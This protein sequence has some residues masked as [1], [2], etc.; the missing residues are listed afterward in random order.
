MSELATSWAHSG[1]E[2]HFVLLAHSIDFYEVPVS[3]KIHRLG[4]RNSGVVAKVKSELTTLVKLRAKVREIQPDFVLSFMEKFNEFTLLSTFGLRIPVFVSDRANPLRTRSWQNKVLRKLTYRLARGVIA[5]TS[6]AKEEIYKRTRHPNIMVIPNPIREVKLTQ[7]GVRDNVIINVGRL[8]PEKGQ[9]YLIEAFS[10]LTDRRWR[11]QI[12]GDGPLRESLNNQVKELGL[13][14]RVEFTGAVTNVDD[15]LATASIFVFSSISEG[16]PNAL[17]EAMAAGLPCVSFDCTAGPRDIINQGS[18][19]Y[20]IPVGDVESLSGSITALQ[21]DPSK[22]KM[23]GGQA[24]EITKKLDGQ[25]I[26][27][28]WFDEIRKS[29]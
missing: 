17:C 16:F 11:L 28:T 25:K 19:G 10:R 7:G 23:I 4:F 21:V 8:V 14:D 15:Y 13:Q 12:L 18:N 2:V 9:S 3:V 24:M 27:Q 20:L 1:N 5:Q 22:R 6:A 26:A 29:I